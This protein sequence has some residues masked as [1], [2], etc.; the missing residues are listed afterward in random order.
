MLRHLKPALLTEYP[1]ALQGKME[2]S[3]LTC[4]VI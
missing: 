3:F 1:A 2:K 4:V